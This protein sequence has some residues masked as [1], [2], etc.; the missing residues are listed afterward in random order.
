MNV[1]SVIAG[2]L[3]LSMRYLPMYAGMAPHVAEDTETSRAAFNG[4][5]EGFGGVKSSVQCRGF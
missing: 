1:A 2:A 3:S 4:T 5:N